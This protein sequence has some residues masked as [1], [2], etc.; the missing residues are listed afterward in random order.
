MIKNLLNDLL[1][2]KKNEIKDSYY[3]SID[4]IFNSFIA[5][6]EKIFPFKL[7]RDL[8]EFFEWLYEE[9]CFCKENLFYFFY[10][11]VYVLDQMIEERDFNIKLIND[12]NHYDDF[13]ATWP[14]AWLPIA[15]QD[16]A[17]F[18]A[19]LSRQPSDQTPLL[20]NYQ[21]EGD[22]NSYF[23]F[24]SIVS[25]LEAEIEIAK[26]VTVNRFNAE[27]MDM[28]IIDEIMRKY[29][30]NAY[31]ISDNVLTDDYFNSQGCQN[32][33]DISDLTSIPKEWL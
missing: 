8:R 21:G 17:Q 19:V 1:A 27:V 25:F 11:G 31:D 32:V 16:I 10:D 20:V 29:S 23:L 22:L 14:L 13:N 15:S 30:P 3:K 33:F 24:P 7:P 28:S 5:Y 9:K 12:G 2:I 18:I 4:L 26:R 6:E